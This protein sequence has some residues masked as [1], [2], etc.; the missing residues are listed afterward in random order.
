[1]GMGNGP[2]NDGP[3]LW[4]LDLEWMD[5]MKNAGNQEVAMRQCRSASLCFTDWPPGIRKHGS[6]IRMQKTVDKTP[7]LS[8][9]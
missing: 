9:I 3:L 1:M 7:G 8:P 6:Q 2:T 5:Y 4:P